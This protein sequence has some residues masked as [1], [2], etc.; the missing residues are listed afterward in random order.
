MST[1]HNRLQDHTLP[2]WHDSNTM[3]R[4]LGLF[5]LSCLVLSASALQVTPNSPCSSFCVDSSDLN[6]ADPNSSNT[7]NKDIVCYDSEYQSSPAGSKFQQCLGCLQNSTYTQG[8]E[9]DQLWFLCR[10]TEIGLGPR[11]ISC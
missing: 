5:T 9:S 7:K 2:F 1:K 11:R 10:Y 6:F 8:G 3:S 4:F